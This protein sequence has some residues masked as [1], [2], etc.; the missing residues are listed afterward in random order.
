MPPDAEK[1]DL[2]NNQVGTTL[3]DASLL[4]LAD[5]IV[6]AIQRAPSHIREHAIQTRHREQKQNIS[7]DSED[8]LDQVN[9]YNLASAK[10]PDAQ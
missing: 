9:A 7:I 8:N 1:H 5:K 10:L 2:S 6:E 3:R 4:C